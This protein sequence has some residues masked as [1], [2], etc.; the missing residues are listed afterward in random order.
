[1]KNKFIFLLFFELFSSCYNEKAVIIDEG[2]RFMELSNE[3][4]LNYIDEYIEVNDVDNLQSFVKIKFYCLFD[5]TI[6]SI[7]Q[8]ESMFGV[9]EEPPVGYFLAKNN[10]VCLVYIDNFDFF[11]N[12]KVVKDLDK[13]IQ[14]N[15]LEL[16]EELYLF[17]PPVW[18]VVYCNEENYFLKKHKG[19]IEY[20]NYECK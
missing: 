19:I 5:K 6:I 17:N 16:S 4:I 11:N 3:I 12:D 1:M 9:R 15:G 13:I 8:I 14:G 10:V 20:V 18:F 7:S 2:S